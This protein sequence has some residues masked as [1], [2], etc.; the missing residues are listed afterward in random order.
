MA[1]YMS[2]VILLCTYTLSHASLHMQSSVK[3]CSLVLQDDVMLL[4]MF[5]ICGR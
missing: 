5:D 1:A 3:L 2:T 4:A